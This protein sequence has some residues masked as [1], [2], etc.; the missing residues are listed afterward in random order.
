MTDEPTISIRIDDR[1]DDYAPLFDQRWAD[2]ITNLAAESK[3]SEPV[4]TLL[5]N[6]RAAANACSMPWLLVHSLKSRWAGFLQT[7]QPFSE[8]VVKALGNRLSDEMGESLSHAK[9]RKLAEAIE[10]IGQEVHEQAGES[11]RSRYDV[12]SLWQ[13]LLED[14]E[15]QVALWGSQRIGYGSIYHSYENFVRDCIGVALGKSEY[16]GQK[17]RT[18]VRDATVAFGKR[19]ADHCLASRPVRIARLVRNALAHKGGKETR[20]LKDYTHDLVV[21]NGVTQILAADTR[22]LLDGLKGRALRLVKKAVTLPN[23]R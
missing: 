14:G 8:R 3:L 7:Q 19:T 5:L 10:R 12:E 1:L 23:V 20:Q 21:E 18:L 15:F 13:A 2:Q 6:W 9:Q 22:K 11:A 4:S 16:R 17:I